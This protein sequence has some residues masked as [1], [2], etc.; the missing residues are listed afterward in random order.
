MHVI[1]KSTKFMFTDRHFL[2]KR[3]TYQFVPLCGLFFCDLRI[4]ITS[5]VS[6]NSSYSKKSNA[7]KNRKN[8]SVIRGL[9]H[10]Y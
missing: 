1:T 6:S 9:C 2:M 8:K 7:E 3:L 4:M 5:L 10:Q